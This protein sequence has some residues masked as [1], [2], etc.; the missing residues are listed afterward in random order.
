MQNGKKK[1]DRFF[2]NND[3]A[4]LVPKICNINKKNQA[5]AT[6]DYFYQHFKT[7]MIISLGE[8]DNFYI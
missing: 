1:K 8:V 3:I 6:L 5:S 7:A 2:I 4:Y